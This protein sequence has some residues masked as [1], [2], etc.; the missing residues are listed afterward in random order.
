MLH[1]IFTSTSQEME[2]SM[3]TT[4]KTKRSTA[5]NIPLALNCKVDDGKLDI[6]VVLKE[7]APK[8]AKLLINAE[9]ID[10]SGDDVSRWYGGQP[11]VLY[12]KP[13]EVVLTLAEQ[14]EIGIDG[15]RFKCGTGGDCDLSQK[16]RSGSKVAT[17]LKNSPIIV[18]I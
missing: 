3:I 5:A 16:V 13:G 1:N 9:E 17:E 10:K 12:V 2:F 4:H 8:M 11:K 7:T 15:I 6:V 14:Q 18:I